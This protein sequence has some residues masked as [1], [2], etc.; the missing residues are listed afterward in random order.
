[1]FLCQKQKSKQTST[2]S[3]KEWTA[4]LPDITRET[5]KRAYENMPKTS[6][7]SIHD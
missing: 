7:F 4:V 6:D 3:A 2:C 1:M 5:S